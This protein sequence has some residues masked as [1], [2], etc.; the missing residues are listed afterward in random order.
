MSK[1]EAKVGQAE[2]LLFWTKLL[3]Q[4]W[5]LGSNLFAVTGY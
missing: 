4:F 3:N 1:V 5:E 2:M